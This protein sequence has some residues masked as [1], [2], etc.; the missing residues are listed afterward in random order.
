MIPKGLHVV[1]D[2]LQPK[3]Q[4]KMRHWIVSVSKWAL[5]PSNSSKNL[6]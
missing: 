1:A 4:P 6:P 2:C 3:I 5:P